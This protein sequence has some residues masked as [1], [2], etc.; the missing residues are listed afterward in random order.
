MVTKASAAPPVDPVEEETE[1]APKSKRD[2]DA[3][4]RAALLSSA[5]IVVTTETSDEKTAKAKEKLLDR[6]LAESGYRARDVDVINLGRRTLGTT[7]GGKYQYARSGALL[8]LKGP[9]YPKEEVLA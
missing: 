2:L 8:T 1:E 7:N 5:P 3:I 4:A 9:R 6:F